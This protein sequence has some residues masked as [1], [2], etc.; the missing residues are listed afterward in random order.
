VLIGPRDRPFACEGLVVVT[1]AT[2]H[3][4]Y[5]AAPAPGQPPGPTACAVFLPDDGRPIAV[6]DP[7]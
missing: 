4:L 1:T 5:L 3:T 7:P 6:V 2:A